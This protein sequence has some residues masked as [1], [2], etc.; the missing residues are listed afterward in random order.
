M[1][2]VT[3]ADAAQI[4][5]GLTARLPRASGSSFAL[6]G[7]AEACAQRNRSI[8]HPGQPGA[9]PDRRTRHPPR[10]SRLLYAR[11]S[12]NY[13]LG[14]GSFESRWSRRCGS[15]AGLA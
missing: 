13:V 4:A 15:G 12:A 3:K 9:Y 8:A 6:R 5:E 2:D 1:G 10:R 14:G 7:G 11:S